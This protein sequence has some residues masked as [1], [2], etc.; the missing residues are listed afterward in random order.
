MTFALRMKS[1]LAV[2]AFIFLG[3]SLYA[4][5]YFEHKKIGDL[6]FKTF[7]RRNKLVLFF[8]DTLAF[9]RY[10]IEF[11]I[12][13]QENADV[14]SY[15]RGMFA[16]SDSLHDY[17]YGDL[18]ALAGDHSVD[19]LQLFQG[20]FTKDYY[21][22]PARSKKFAK[23]IPQLRRV[24]RIQDKA[25]ERGK[26]EAPY[27]SIDYILLAISDRSHFQRPGK[28]FDE[29]LRSIDPS[30]FTRIAYFNRH[31]SEHS[32]GLVRLRK[33]IARDLMHLDNTAKYAVVH[34]L[35][36]EYMHNAAIAYCNGDNKGLAKNFEFALVFNAYADHFLQDAFSSGHML[37]KRSWRGA[38]NKGVHDYYSRMGLNVRNEQGQGWRAY[39]DNFYDSTAFAIAID[40]DYCSL[41]DLWQYFSSVRLEYSASL[42][43]WQDAPAPESLIKKIN[44]NEMPADSIP[45][46]M[47]RSFAAYRL[48]PLPVAGDRY[49]RQL[50]LKRGSKDG[51]FAEVGANRHFD[52]SQGIGA[53]AGVGLGADIT[54]YRGR[55]LGLAHSGKNRE[56]VYWVG[57]L[58]DYSAYQVC[59]K[60]IQTVAAGLNFTYL[61]RLTAQVDCG[62][63]AD[64]KRH[65]LLRP[66]AGYEFKTPALPVA[67]SLKLFADISKHSGAK[68][69]MT[70]CLRL[71]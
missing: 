69:G 61:D 66:M 29:M 28:S 11:P 60:E 54:P 14:C 40:A 31:K 47:H 45:A 30:L 16:I 21:A 62:L 25:I 52:E 2:S 8:T 39:G 20:L 27:A 70:L 51:F 33:K 5:Q 48:V 4:G 15:Y 58:V 46:F 34:A 22:Q 68:A 43:R 44:R 10:G 53:N 32:R 38:D 26:N 37:V 36:L 13:F 49:N 9:G 59:K 1:I 23:L 24:M 3:Q 42:A 56:T 55:G 57:F 64:K 12:P 6:A 71:Y 67:P 65:F 19:P 18:S 7:I 17:S 35:A 50:R 63:M 41:N